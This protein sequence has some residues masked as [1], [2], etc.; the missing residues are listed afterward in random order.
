MIQKENPEQFSWS[1]WRAGSPVDL[2]TVCREHFINDYKRELVTYA[3][4]YCNAEF[5]LCR[6]KFGCI[7]VMFFKDG[8][9]FWF[10]LTKKEF[11]EIF[12]L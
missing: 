6:P 3:I 9:H 4:G 10:H 5:L 12:K 7:A 11:K 8:H 1:R 2:G